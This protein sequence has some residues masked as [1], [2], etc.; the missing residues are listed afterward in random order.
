MT[1]S[2]QGVEQ[3]LLYD[4]KTGLL[5]WRVRK[6]ARAAVGSV[7]GHLNR[8]G[9]VEIR[10]NGRTMQAH[11]IAWYL[12]HGIDPGQNGIDHINCNPSDNRI[13]NLRLA[14]HAQN[15]WNRPKRKG[16]SSSLKGVSWHGQTGKWQSEIRHRGAT[17]YLGYFDDEASAHKAYACAALRYHGEF[18]RLA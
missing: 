7:A 14:D 8:I 16:T 1:I 11:R 2:L 12:Y 4:C 15:S 18:A 10:V 6:G 5:T 17:I 9:R 3:Y 13:V